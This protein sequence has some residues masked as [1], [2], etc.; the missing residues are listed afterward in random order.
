MMEKIKMPTVILVD[1]KE[2]GTD[3]KILVRYVYHGV[4]T[5]LRAGDAV[6]INAAIPNADHLAELV[7]DGLAAEFLDD[8]NGNMPVVKAIL[9]EFGRSAWAGFVDV[10]GWFWKKVRKARNQ[11]AATAFLAEHEQELSDPDAF[12]DGWDAE[13]STELFRAGGAKALFLWGF[14]EGKKD[15]PLAFDLD[16]LDDFDLG[17]LD[18]MNKAALNSALDALDD[19]SLEGLDG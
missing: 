16:G 5:V 15:D 12:P 6:K 10:H 19:F 9:D 8:A 7:R 17:A 18:D 3:D 2:L 13:F 11:E 14:T 1:E 4:Y